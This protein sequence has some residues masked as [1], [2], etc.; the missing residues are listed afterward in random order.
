MKSRNASVPIIDYLQR[1]GGAPTLLPTAQR[2]L[3]LRQDVLALLPAT[4]GE[5]CE[6]SESDGAVSL[7][8]ASAGVAAKLRQTLP[9]VERGLIE[10]GWQ[11]SAIRIRVQ[12]RTIDDAPVTVTP[13][14]GPDMPADAI[15]AFASLGREVPDSP[16]KDAIERLVRRRR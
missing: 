8:V 1:Q 11:V 12:P 5:S 3:E 2:M 4:L 16:L 10:R 14:N 13:R 9:R 6:V 15:E 7:R